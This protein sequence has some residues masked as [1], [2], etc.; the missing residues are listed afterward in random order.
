MPS[1]QSLVLL[2]HIPLVTSTDQHH[3]T[4]ARLFHHVVLCFCQPLLVTG[5]EELVDAAAQIQLVNDLKPGR[6]LP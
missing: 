6:F 3:I 2:D 1:R 5:H 4:C